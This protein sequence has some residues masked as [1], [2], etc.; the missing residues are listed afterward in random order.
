MNATPKELLAALSD[1]PNY[2]YPRVVIEE[3]I[4]RREEMIPALLSV[5]EDAVKRPKYYFEGGRWKALTFA[6]F[7]LAQFRET[8]A[9]KP[10]CAT[11]A[12]AAEV[13][14]RLWGDQICE[15][16][17]NILASVYDGDDAPLRKL[18]ASPGVYEYV[19]GATVPKAY[20]CL[21]QAGRI[22]REKLES[23]A[24]ELLGKKMEREYSHAWDGWTA[25]C[26]DMGFSR[27]VPLIER[28][29]E[30]GLCDPSY[31]GAEEL[32]RRAS[33]DRVQRTGEDLDLIDDTI[34]ETD[35]WACWKKPRRPKPA[36]PPPR[37]SEPRTSPKTGRNE[38]CPC[39]S[40]KKFKKCCGLAV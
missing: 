15:G 32:I 18:A 16:M 7:L 3:M 11:L 24:K 13:T 23:R 38:S 5:I 36:P 19:R 2:P 12:H 37:Y 25:L 21:L 28:A 20:L 27:L 26:A 35:W 33:S 40:G 22:S 39:G 10:L 6:A 1:S 34:G 30:D 14:N 9:F 31:Y 17:G 4:R 8:R 29:L